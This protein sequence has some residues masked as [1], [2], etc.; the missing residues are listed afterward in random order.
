M[1]SENS[2]AIKS[3]AVLLAGS[4][5]WSSSAYAEEEFAVDNTPVASKVH[6]WDFGH[7]PFTFVE[8]G[9]HNVNLGSGSPSG[10]SRVL[11]GELGASLQ[12]VDHF[13][14]SYAYQKFRSDK[15]SGDLT[16]TNKELGLGAA[17][18]LNYRNMLF[19]RYLRSSKDIEL[20]GASCRKTGDDGWGY[21][22]GARYL[23]DPNVAFKLSYK[24]YDRD[25]TS[26][27][28]LRISLVM[29]NRQS[30]NS[31]YLGYSSLDEEGW[32][33]AYRIGF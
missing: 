2:L 33:L 28:G 9:I 3:C 17:L 15:T 13:F 20:C 21:E 8:L 25:Y 4:L 1:F 29:T 12:L 22:L 16:V 23:I 11:G 24:D 27:S 14:V 31:W 26:D 32:K 30:M 10:H 5:A 19:A 7:R 6:P 18:P